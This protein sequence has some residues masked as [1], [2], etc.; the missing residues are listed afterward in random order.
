[1]PSS[2]PSFEV[3]PERGHPTLK[4]ATALMGPTAPSATAPWGAA[5]RSWLPMPALPSVTG[6]FPGSR[7]SCPRSEARE[8]MVL[9]EWPPAKPLL[10][11]RTGAGRCLAANG[12]LRSAVPRAGRPQARGFRSAP[13]TARVRRASTCGRLQHLTL[14]PRRR[15]KLGHQPAVR[16]SRLRPVHGLYCGAALPYGCASS[17][18]LQP[19]RCGP[20]RVSG[21]MRFRR[22]CERVL[23]THVASNW[24]WRTSCLMA[25]R[26][27]AAPAGSIGPLRDSG[28][29]PTSIA[30]FLATS[31]RFE[32]ARGNDPEAEHCATRICTVLY[33]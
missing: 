5:E 29:A 26:T 21:G 12:A 3:S 22:Q 10:A 2:R 31:N 9:K 15:V 19:L 20:R 8:A 27:A 25:V 1:M 32:S 24:Y 23:P 13:T 33:P 7:A 6:G 16:T 11:D 17:H 28:A 18:G 4:L 30:R 14:A